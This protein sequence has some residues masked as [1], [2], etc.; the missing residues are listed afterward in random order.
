MLFNA[1]RSE[2]QSVRWADQREGGGKKVAWLH[3]EAQCTAMEKSYVYNAEEREGARPG[4]A[5]YWIR[6]RVVLVLQTAN[7]S[8]QKMFAK[9][10]QH[11]VLVFLKRSFKTNLSV[12]QT[13][14]SHR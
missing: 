4:V 6:A 8:F 2:I 13:A 3:H 7:R 10:Y 11:F 12:K 5:N 1:W 9:K 14:N